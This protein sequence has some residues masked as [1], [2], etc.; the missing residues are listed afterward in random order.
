MD[1]HDR[2]WGRKGATLSDKTARQDPAW[3]ALPAGTAGADRVG[4]DQP[5]AKTAVCSARRPRGKAGRAPFR[6]RRARL[7]TA[8]TLPTPTAIRVSALLVPFPLGALV[9]QRRQ[10]ELEW[11]HLLVHHACKVIC[12]AGQ[13][14]PDKQHVLLGV[15]ATS[16]QPRQHG[17]RDI[18][19]RTPVAE[20]LFVFHDQQRGRDLLRLGGQLRV[21]KEQLGQQDRTLVIRQPWFPGAHLTI[22]SPG[23]PGVAALPASPGVVRS[24]ARGGA[25]AAPGT[26]LLLS[27]DHRSSMSA[28]RK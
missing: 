21:P 22:M 6:A 5:R 4:A 16:V 20:F 19:G 15:L 28:V 12:R 9:R 10:R 26:V 14:H 11:L 23:R 18:G 8:V 27:E 3:R 1:L 2:E 13:A 7:A 25:E 24:A 17:D